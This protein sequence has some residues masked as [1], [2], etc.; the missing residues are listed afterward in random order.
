MAIF[1]GVKRV[2]AHHAYP[3]TYKSWRSVESSRTHPRLC[4]GC[5]H[6]IIPAT[7]ACRE[8]ETCLPKIL[9]TSRPHALDTRNNRSI[10]TTNECRMCWVRQAHTT[11]TPDCS[12]SRQASSV[13]P[14]HHSLVRD[15]HASSETLSI[16]A[17]ESQLDP[18]NFSWTRHPPMHTLRYISTVEK[19]MHLSPHGGCISCVR[20]TPLD[21][22]ARNLVS[23]RHFRC[24]V[25]MCTLELVVSKS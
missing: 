12:S 25:A 23:R 9:D 2:E 5:V 18:S 6:S 24:N 13:M 10:V 4:A 3:T 16:S 15:N 21:F 22:S 1:T 7:N 14:H 19:A 20:A 17:L 8:W 11:S